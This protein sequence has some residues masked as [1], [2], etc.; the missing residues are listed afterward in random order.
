MQNNKCVLAVC[1]HNQIIKI[2]PLPKVSGVNGE[3][4]C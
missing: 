3:Q 1:G 2:Y 4:V